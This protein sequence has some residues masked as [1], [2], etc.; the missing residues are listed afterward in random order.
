MPGQSDLSNRTILCNVCG[1]ENPFTNGF[2]AKCG[3]RL[4]APQEG[5]S[6]PS[7]API[8][9]L[10]DQQPHK[11]GDYKL[12]KKPV[13][14]PLQ[15]GTSRKVLLKGLVYGGGALTVVLCAAITVLLYIAVFNGPDK[16]GQDSSAP[17]SS[18]NPDYVSPSIQGD[19]GGLIE[20]TT[21][22]PV[23]QTFEGLWIENNGQLTYSGGMAT[24]AVVAYFKDG[25]V[26]FGNYGDSIDYILNNRSGS[27]IDGGSPFD[28]TPDALVIY[29]PDGKPVTYMRDGTT[30]W[31]GDRTFTPDPGPDGGMIVNK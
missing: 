13:V 4:V 20:I 30:W 7:T 10:E 6:T 15:T 3:A 5:I 16:P 12:P 24:V 21:L 31:I 1:A 25:R 2:C 17:D 23:P 22:T 27:G 14:K 18:S 28:L 26:Y 9:D 29:T 11:P 19:E 8:P